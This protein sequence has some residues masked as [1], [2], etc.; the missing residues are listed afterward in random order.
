MAASVAATFA[1]VACPPSAPAGKLRAEEKMIC[2]AGADAEGAA[3]CDGDCD[4]DGDGDDAAREP[5]A[6]APVLPLAD[7]AAGESELDADAPALPLADGDDTREPDAD[8]AAPREPD[9]DDALVDDGEPAAR[10]TDAERD[11]LEPLD[12][13][14]ED[15][16]VDAGVPEDDRLLL[17][18]PL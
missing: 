1:G 14:A 6:D 11:A 18:A 15:D 10:E 16:A 13:V 9:A 8:G 4:G 3:E 7:G 12:T 5:D 2:W 17:G